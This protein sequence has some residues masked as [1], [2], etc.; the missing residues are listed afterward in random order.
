MK[1]FVCSDVHGNVRALDAVLAAWK[2]FSPCR[3]LFLGDA[4]GYGAHP[5]A[6]LERLLAVPRAQLV[7]G[8]HDRAVL[9]LSLI[10]I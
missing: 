7:M 8:N 10:H 5:D 9:D 1:L 6:C 2:E 4:V 3:F